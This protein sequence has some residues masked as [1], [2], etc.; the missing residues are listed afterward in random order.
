[1]K[2]VVIS[3][4][5]D[6]RLLAD[7]CAYDAEDAVVA[8]LGAD[9]FTSATNPA[10]IDKT[11]DIGFV[12]GI[13]YQR[14]EDSLR[15]LLPK[16]RERIDGPLIGYLFGAYGAKSVN[17]NPLKRLTRSRRTSFSRFDRL[18]LGIGDDADMIRDRLKVETHY[19]PMA[20]N[21][22]AVDAKPYFSRDDRPIT[23]NAFGRQK[24]DFMDAFCD[25]LNVSERNELVYYSN[26]LQPGQA[27]DLWRYRDMFWQMLRRSR[28]SSAFDHLFTNNVKAQLSY[29]GPRWF[30]SLAAGTVVIGRAPD[31]EDRARLLD[32]TDSVIDL[33]PDPL[34]A[35][36]ELV[37]L[38]EDDDR[39]RRASRENLIQMS[40]R[41]D[42]GHRVAEILD[43][44]RLDRPES[45]R[46]RLW[47][48]EET[49][50]RLK[51]GASSRVSVA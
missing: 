43:V 48:L 28:L 16:V 10:L 20:A 13:S 42:W 39:L 25:R 24:K 27:S 1:M 33:S 50:V 6:H 22:L 49:A 36:E 32:W 47:Q 45:L 4:R 14:V 40:L 19:L 46:Q 31:T 11:Y 8:A 5:S 21:V 17:R 23:V 26:L 3:G 9:L 38:V 15:R 30:E 35:T 7:A 34:Q 12:F 29:V 41:H 2:A 51:K 37:A 44:E 18:Y